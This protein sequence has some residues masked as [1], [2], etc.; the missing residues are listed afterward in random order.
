MRFQNK[1]MMN[2]ANSGELKKLN[3]SRMS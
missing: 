3:R 1:P 2:T